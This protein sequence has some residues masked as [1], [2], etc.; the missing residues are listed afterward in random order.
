MTGPKVRSS[1]TMAA[2]V[3]AASLMLATT[4]GAE[5]Y[6]AVTKAALQAV[7][8]KQLEALGRD[9]GA[10]AEAFAAP[11]IRSKFPDPASFLAMVKSSYGALI[12]PKTTNFAG[13]ESSPHGP[14]Q[15]VTVVAADGTVWTAIYAFEK[16]EG[17]WR[18]IGVGLEEDKNQQAI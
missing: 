5:E 18:I 11:A 16:V 7:V 15:K 8:T 12:K 13:V 9:D 6:D 1:V 14:L 10:A 2:V 3:F 17:E 4:A